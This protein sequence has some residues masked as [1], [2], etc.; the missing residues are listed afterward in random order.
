MKRKRFEK[1]M[2]SQHKSQARDIRQAVRTIIEL[3][4]YSEGHKG[5]LMV[6]NKKVECFTEATLTLTAKCM[7]GS[8]E[9][10]ALLE[11]SLDR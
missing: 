3:R 9:V 11:R 6:Y 7:P 4:H 1:L 5:I 8:R 10:R 2:I